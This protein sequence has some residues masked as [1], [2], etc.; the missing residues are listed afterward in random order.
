M[1]VGDGGHDLDRQRHRAVGGPPVDVVHPETDA[2]EVK[3]S[4]GAREVLGFV[5]HPGQMLVRGKRPESGNQIV[6]AALGRQS[7]LCR[8]DSHNSNGV[9]R[10]SVRSAC[11]RGCR[12]EA[13]Q[14]I[15]QTDSAGGARRPKSTPC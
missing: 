4:D 6:D 12:L 3:R 11:G 7:M 10:R 2:F 1:N 9:S 15:W 14:A 5:D 13:A 8:H